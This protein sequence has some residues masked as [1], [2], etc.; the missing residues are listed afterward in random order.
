MGFE[1]QT[2]YVYEDVREVIRVEIVQVDR[3]M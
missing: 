3:A 1:L 2:K